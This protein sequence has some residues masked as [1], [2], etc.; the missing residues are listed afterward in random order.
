MLD[1]AL[2]GH[3]VWDGSSWPGSEVAHISGCAPAFLMGTE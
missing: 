2:L 3:Q 1:V